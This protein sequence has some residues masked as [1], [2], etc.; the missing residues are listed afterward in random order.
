MKPKAVS[1]FTILVFVM[2]VSVFAG[3]PGDFE[4][5]GDVDLFDLLVFAEQWLLTG[6]TLT[7][8]IAPSPE[9]DGKVDWL[10]FAR[11][12]EYWLIY[13]PPD[14]V[15]IPGGE[16]EMGDH[17]GV[18]LGDDER[19]VH[20]VRVDSFC[21]GKHEITNQQ[22]CNYLNSAYSQG[23]VQVISGAVYPTGGGSAYCDTTTSS[24]YSGI[25]WN[26]S[27]FSAVSAKEDHPMVE[28]SWYGSTAYCNY[29]GYRLPTEAE[30][31]YAARGGEHSP[32]YRY[33]WGDSIDGSKANYWSSG[34]P[35]ESGA[36][37]WTTPVGYYSANGYG[38]YDMAGNVWEW[39]NDWY[40]ST[41][42][43]I[44]P[45]DNPTGPASGI[46]RVLRGG[47]WFY[48]TAGCRVAIRFN[49]SALVRSSNIGFR[50]VLDFK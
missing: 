7:A 4:P 39:C 41:Y 44:S 33:P 11:L 48:P 8:D 9:G 49:L 32:Y 16:F 6:D 12:A 21:M 50:V 10:D 2:C 30:W 37:P 42:Y 13:V 47:S 43:G 19:P 31:E 26:G 23:L 36:Y 17:Y 1:A 20:R 18:P 5:D 24:S 3:I 38:L 45:Y 35:Y 34:D 22:Y 46:Y 28:I 40:S 29:Y 27:S 14:M 15:L 25:T